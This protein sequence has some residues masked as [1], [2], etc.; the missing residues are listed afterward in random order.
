MHMRPFRWLMLLASLTAGYTVSAQFAEPTYDFTVGAC[1]ELAFICSDYSDQD[2]LDYDFFVD[3]V[4]VTSPRVA[5]N[6]DTISIYELANLTGD[7]YNGPYDITSWKINGVEHQTTFND[8]QELVDFMNAED[9][10][11]NWQVELINNRIS[12]GNVANTYSDMFIFAQSV[13]ANE[14]M[15][16]K[17]G[18]QGGG[19]EFG[20]SGG[21]HTIEAFFNGTLL[22]EATVTVNC[23]V[24]PTYEYHALTIPTAITVCPDLGGL[25][26]PVV[27]F[28]VSPPADYVVISL[29]ANDCFTVSPVAIGVDTVQLTYCDASSTCSVVNYIFDAGLDMPITSSTV[30]DTV[31]APSGNVTFCIDTLQLPGNVVSVQDVCAGGDD[32]VSFILTP[33]TVCLKYRGLV[34]GGTDTSCVVVCDD[35]GFCD[36]TQVIVTTVEPNVYPDVD[37]EFTIEEGTVSSTVLNTGDFQ[38][39]LAGLENSCPNLSGTFVRFLVHPD[40]F[41]VDF[42]GLLPGTERAC[43]DVT[44]VTNR[45]KR[46]NITVH[47]VPRAPARDTIRIRNGDTRLWCFGPYELAGAPVRLTDACVA[48]TQYVSLS[49]SADITCVNITANA[50]GVQDLCMT[51]CD[52]QNVC[53]RISLVVEV[54]PNDDDRLP[55]AEDDFF[56]V[57]PAS[58]NTLNP[59]SNDE[60]LTP[61]VFAH[62]IAGPA[63]GAASFN[64]NLELVYNLGNAPCAEYSLI[65]EVCNQF[66]CDQATVVLANDC[67]NDKPDV[68]NRSGFSPNGD[69]TNETWELTNIEFYPNSVVKVYNRWGSKVLE[70]QGYQNDWGGDFDGKALPDGTYFFVAELNERGKEP[71]AGYVQVRR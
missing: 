55:R 6:A 11:G 66:G 56:V 15:P 51:L 22:D 20:F 61:F 4:E 27:D 16:R 1:S 8:P 67:G 58:S 71:I 19:S 43:I 24:A 59:L 36:T 42:T 7:G 39:A 26:G 64:S 41:S 48:A 18:T 12:G 52:A 53:D 5:C 57:N 10:A 13:A 69:G 68:I 63:Q 31:A 23:T 34:S 30:F 2:F 14:V 60:S 44:D 46:F 29:A 25:S 28:F 33:Q 49:P 32:F 65:Y 54:L 70:V 40:N 3:G 35:L 62:V 37:L 45:T 9:P 47:V 38:S 17:V 50:L 21:T